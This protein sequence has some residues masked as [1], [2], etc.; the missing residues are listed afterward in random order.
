MCLVL[1]FIIL[2]D[3]LISNETELEFLLNLFYFWYVNG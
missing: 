1:S 2:T 3:E